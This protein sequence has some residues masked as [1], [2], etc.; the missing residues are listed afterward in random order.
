MLEALLL[1]MKSTVFVVGALA[2]ASFLTI[3][4]ILRGA[5]PLQAVAVE[6]DTEA[7]SSG[8]RER[9]MLEVT[10][11]MVLVLVGAYVALAQGIGWSIPVLA[12]GV[13]LVV[14]PNF[15]GRR[16]RHASPSVRRASELSRIFLNAALLAGILIVANVAAFR[17]GRQGIDL[18]RERTF[19]LASLTLN[20][21]VKL[22]RPVTFHLV[23]GS[24]ARSARQLDRVSQLLELYRAARPDLVKLDTLNPFTELA[25][26]ED[27]AKR[28]PDLGVTLT[29]G[30]GVLIEHGEGSDAQFAVVTG[31]E[32]YE[33]T[34][35]A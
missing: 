18:T 15:K 10:S 20:Q 29:R 4:W 6:P 27:L 32:M 31:Q 3:Y 14:W 7:P 17:Y 12:A 28:V 9:L 16:Y 13:G 24:G 33:P 26:A 35:P 5:P 11:G 2:L 23:Y 19:S 25:R 22:N 34:S 1:L 8:Y 30:G 21:L